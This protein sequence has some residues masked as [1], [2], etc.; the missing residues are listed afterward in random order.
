MNYKKIFKYFLWEE[1]NNTA[2]NTALSLFARCLS[3]WV[4]KS[5]RHSCAQL[6]AEV[7]IVCAH[8]DAY[9]ELFVLSS[10]STKC[11]EKQPQS[12]ILPPSLFVLFSFGDVVFVHTCMCHIL[13]GIKNYQPWFHHFKLNTYLHI[14][15]A[16]FMCFCKIQWSLDVYCKITLLHSSD[17]WRIQEI[18][19]SWNTQPAIARNSRI[20]VNLS[21]IKK[22]FFL[23]FT[24]LN[25][26]K[27]LCSIY[28]ICDKLFVRNYL[29]LNCYRVFE[30]VLLSNVCLK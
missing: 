21:L 16:D 5:V 6:L 14:L 2:S 29:M 30:V 3:V 11:R 20:S 7:W 12:M 18:V 22:M 10:T 9:L 27:V 28:F 15:L 25:Y 26:Y 24:V 23:V 4:S 13:F 8:V 17:I 1:L 19:I